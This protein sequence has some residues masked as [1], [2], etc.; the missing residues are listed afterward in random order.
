MRIDLALLFTWRHIAKVRN[1]VNSNILILDEV[2]D[3]SLDEAGTE[4]FLKIVEDLA[5]ESNIIVISHKTDALADRF[6]RTLK[7]DKKKNFSE[8]IT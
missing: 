7:F 4:E 8:M 1:S 2:M 3:S 5:K 6:E